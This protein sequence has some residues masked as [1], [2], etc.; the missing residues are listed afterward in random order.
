M[1]DRSARLVP[2]CGPTREQQVLAQGN[3]S[4]GLMPMSV[5]YLANSVSNRGA[6]SWTI[7]YGTVTANG[8]TAR[9]RPGQRKDGTPDRRPVLHPRRASNH[10]LRRV[11]RDL[12]AINAAGNVLPANYGPE[13]YRN[14]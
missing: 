1:N 9:P 11:R 5:D 4:V 3:S 14:H 13:R 12:R 10:Q 6:K 2:G 8:A 7:Y